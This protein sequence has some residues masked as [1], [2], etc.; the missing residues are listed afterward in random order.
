MWEPR[1][2]ANVT[3]PST[4]LEAGALIGARYRAE[5]P[6]H[7]ARTRRA[8]AGTD[9]QTGQR[10]HLIEVSAGDAGS[11]GPLLRVE[12]AHL[13]KVLDVVQMFGAAVVVIEGVSGGTLADHA[14]PSEN[15]EAVRAILRVADAVSAIHASG[16]AHGCLRPEAIVAEPSGRAGP[17]VSFAPPVVGPSPYRSP[18]RGESAPPAEADDAWAV[19]GLLHRMLTGRDPPLT[20]IADDSELAA[21]G[22]TDASLRAALLHALARDPAQRSS[23]LKPLKRELARWFVDHAGEEP[24]HAVGISSRPP[25]LPPSASPPPPVASVV[26]VAGAATAAPRRGRGKLVVGLAVGGIVLGLGAAWAVSALRKPPVEI[27]EK[28]AAPPAAAAAP[29]AHAIDLSEVPVTG[30][31]DA[32]T[33]DRMATCVAGYLPKGAFVVT[34]SFDWLC[35]ESDPRMGAEKLRTAVVQGGGQREV[36]EAMKIFSRLGWHDMTAFAVIRSGCCPDA[37][38][39]ELPEPVEGCADMGQALRDVA[40]SVL[41]NQSF[42]EPLERYGKAVNCEVDANRAYLFR[43]TG[44]A[45][46]YQ[47]LAFRD[48]VKATQ[49]P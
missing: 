22:V 36:T 30:D 29:S 9:E 15:V 24:G 27:V 28:S 46:H 12:H 33:G 17:V 44:R 38:P 43:H 41:A 2:P 16:G 18:E 42:D 1:R 31:Q 34:P 39:I 3:G 47:D 4:Q 49:A 23:D 14:E 13:A 26:P 25:P 20:G 7:D 21:A 48:L 40:K 6:V 5:E 37:K 11:L 45:Q 10:V 35:A 19:A 32:A 8:F